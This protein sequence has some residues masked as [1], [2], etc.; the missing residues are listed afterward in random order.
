[1]KCVCTLLRSRREF[2]MEVMLSNDW[3]INSCSDPSSSLIFT[4]NST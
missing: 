3:L 2:S 4:L 1:M